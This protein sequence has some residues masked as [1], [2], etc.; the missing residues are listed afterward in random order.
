[1]AV[2]GRKGQQVPPDIVDAASTTLLHR[3]PDDKGLYF[4][5]DVAFGFRRL[6]I[7][8]TSKAGHQPMSSDD[9]R[10]TVVFNGEIYNYIEL[11]AEL[12]A[13][14][15]RFQ[16]ACDT[17]LVGV[18]SPVGPDCGAPLRGMWATSFMTP[19]QRSSSVRDRLGVK[20]PVWQNA[21]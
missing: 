14:G 21:D 1:V 3:G 11:R 2:V 12:A 13:L 4:N 20:P 5:H 10:F 17:S 19:R 6:S 9:G 18:L 7:I 8:D 16:S 15:H